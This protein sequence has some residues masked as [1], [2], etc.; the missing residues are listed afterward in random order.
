MSDFGQVLAI[1]IVFGSPV[2]AFI[3]F[4]VLGHRERMEMIRNGMPP[5]SGRKWEKRAREYAEWNARANPQ[6]SD[7]GAPPRP[8][9]SAARPTPPP[10]PPFAT[11]PVPVGK[12]PEKSVQDGVVTASIGLA[13]TIGLSF[14]G[15]HSDPAFPVPTIHPGPWLLGG[16]IPMFVGIAQIINGVLGGAVIGGANRR[17]YVPPYT[18]IPPRHDAGPRPEPPPWVRDA[19]P[20]PGRT[21]DQPRIARPVPPPDIR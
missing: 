5:M 19:A 21:D 7:F 20:Q 14:I 15:Y 2:A 6:P 12:T 11:G 4:R 13:L 10:P 17:P 3:V 1:L 8:G 18:D 9:P 16:L